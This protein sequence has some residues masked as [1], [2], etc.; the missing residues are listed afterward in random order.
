[1]K[2]AES[3]FATHRIA[4]AIADEQPVDWTPAE[5][6][7]GADAAELESLRVLDDVARAFRSSGG[8]AG[9]RRD[10]EPLFRWSGLDVHERLGEGLSG[11]VFCAWDPTLQREVA[12]KLRVRR[13]PLS[14]PA[15]RQLL[16]EARQ[17]ARI[18]HH[19]VLAVYG[20]DVDDGRAGIWSELIDGS[21][22]AQ[23]LERNGPMGPGEALAVGIDLCRALGVVHAAG[24][25]H[26]DVKAE[27]VMR[28]RGGRTVLMDF[29][30][31][32]RAD[33]LDGRLL[34]SGTRRYLAPELLDGSGG[35]TAASD[36]Y[37]LAVLVYHLLSAAFPR[38]D[39]GSR[40]A[41]A[42]RRPDLPSALA[43][44]IDRLIAD[45]PALRPASA[46][47]MAARLLALHPGTAEPAAARPRRLLVAA[48]ATAAAVALA[49]A[50]LAR[51]GAGP[52]QASIAFANAD[53]GA[54]LVDGSPV[55]LGDALHL[56]VR[57]SAPSHVYVINQDADG[58]LAVLFPLAGLDLANP[59]PAGR[60]VVLP[61]SRGGRSLAWE[62]ASPSDS[63][64]FVVIA[65]PQPLPRLQARLLER[66]AAAID[67]DVDQRGAG[68]LRAH[69]P[70]TTLQAA[71]LTELVALAR[72]DQP[73]PSRLQVLVIRLPH[74]PP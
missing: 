54:A 18:R 58:A 49:I 66:P 32:G 69:D 27:N 39:D 52:W 4:E 13:D 50:L 38:A 29:G 12:L 65:S 5:R 60:D 42:S 73:D 44:G 34:L 43:D 56:T 21:T 2:S 57:A 11:E 17:L 26:G 70:G 51:P 48:A 25:V 14:D 74:S 30:A 61:G 16:N 20:A 40:V 24:L 8:H 7:L 15:N 33:D 3:R 71:A 37:A 53:T 10:A 68:R 22:L 23:V 41:L 35:P 59:L 19:N 31:S 47:A 45:D 1:M 46:A 64:E 9:A 72:Q 6:A 28:E 55:A 62:I 63:D 36:L 67:P